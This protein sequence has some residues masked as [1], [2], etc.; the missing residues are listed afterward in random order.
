M[1]LLSPL[2]RA[3]P[4]SPRLTVYN[5]ARGTRMEFSGQTLE[6]WASKVANLLD[7]EFELEDD[8]SVLIDLPVS[9]QAT[10]IA[11]GTYN[12][13][14]IPRFDGSNF[15]GPSFDGPTHNPTV[16]FTSLAGADTWNGIPECDCVVVSDDAFGR[17][18]VEAGGALPP[19]T[20]DFGPTVRFYG[21]QYFGESPELSTFARDELGAERYLVPH[22]STT[23]E[24]EHAVLAPLAAGGSVV[25]AAGLVST[26]RMNEIAQIEKVTR[27]LTAG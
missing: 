13:S 3:D 18:V 26:N 12:S 11:L 17:G 10:V 23:D 27:F 8:S 22:W 9:W 4:A 5:D 14:R 24:F 25:V 2:L 21:D 7:E 6:N 19:G 1:S 15:D 16:V 20:I